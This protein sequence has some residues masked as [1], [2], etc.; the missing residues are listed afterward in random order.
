MAI[1]G[2]SEL[3]HALAMARVRAIRL[4]LLELHKAVLDVERRRYEHAHGRI[5]NPHDALRLVMQDP[6]FR[7]LAPLAT[8]IV[9]MDERLADHA[10]FTAEEADAFAGRVRALLMR[11]GGDPKFR[12]NYHRSLQETPEVVVAHGRVVRLVTGPAEV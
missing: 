11:D 2:M 6:W 12:D 3:A 9:Q 4:A 8:M 7:W 5:E 1:W 10:P